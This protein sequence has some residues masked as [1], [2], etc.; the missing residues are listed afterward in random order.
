MVNP[1]REVDKAEFGQGVGNGS[2]DFRLDNRR[3]RTQR[4]HVALIE[5]PE[6]AACR[7]IGAPH[8]LDLIPLEQLRQ[9]CLVMRDHPGQRHRQ[10][11]A[12]P[13]VCES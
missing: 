5:L 1:Y 13:E 2:A 12:Q 3:G 9:L 8:R 4:V 11:V 6:A 10:V 7:T